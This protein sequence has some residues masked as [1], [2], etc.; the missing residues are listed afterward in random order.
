MP[1]YAR[2]KAVLM[3]NAPG[4]RVKDEL[5]VKNRLGVKPILVG[6]CL[7]LSAAAMSGCAS[8][9]I[10][11]LS[12][13]PGEAVADQ[14]ELRSAANA[15][16]D[17]IDQAGWTLSATP[18]EARRS[19][20]NRLIG[21]R[22]DE[23]EA[24]PED[25]AVTLYL[26]SVSTPQAVEADLIS[27]IDGAD[28]VAAQTLTVASSDDALGARALADD[29]AAVERALGAVRRATAFFDAV[30]AQGGWDDASVFGLAAQLETARAAETRLAASAD[31]LAER[32]WA[33][34]SGLFG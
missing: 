16:A 21:G 28:D 30:L 2:L 9:P 7:A 18:A 4:F 29:L 17:R 24:E 12:A 33:A 14:V 3:G 20:L 13:A 1:F 19:F 5:M 32:R 11:M 34:R 6:L 26:A 15:L 27:L 22:S 8:A 31:A 23:G 10:D 25:D